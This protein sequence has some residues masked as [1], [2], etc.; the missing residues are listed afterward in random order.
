MKQI[1]ELLPHNATL[2]VQVVGHSVEEMLDDANTV[3]DQI[4]PDTYIKVPTSE[5]GLKVIKKLKAKNVNVTATAIYTKFQGYL[6]IAAG[7]DYIAPYYNRMQNMNIDAPDA[8][9]NFANMIAEN[10]SKTKI[11]AASFHNVNQVTEAFENGA[12]AATMGPDILESALGMPAIAQAVHD[13]TG[14]WESVFGTGSTVASL[15]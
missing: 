4:G 11:L 3:L 9:A 5:D 1:R 15:K 8:I 12:Q 13:F 7:A 6:A 14:D 2:H 10:N